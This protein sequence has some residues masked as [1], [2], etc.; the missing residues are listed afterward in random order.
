MQLGASVR[1]E[2]V[3]NKANFESLKHDDRSECHEN[4]GEMFESEESV[5]YLSE[6]KAPPLDV[7]SI[8]EN[9]GEAGQREISQELNLI[10]S[11]ETDESNTRII[12]IE[13]TKMQTRNIKGDGNCFFR[14][15]S[16]CVSESEDN[17]EAI[18]RATCSYKLENEICSNLCKGILTYL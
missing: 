12:E 7:L 10:F 6:E 5:E 4:L 8:E 15:I 1:T 9:L 14:V 11:E 16:C 3:E 13:G 17:N 18:R 2:N